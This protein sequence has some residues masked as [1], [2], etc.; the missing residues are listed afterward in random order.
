MPLPVDN[1]VI[2]TRQVIDDYLA[3]FHEIALKEL[4]PFARFN[5]KGGL[6]NFGAFL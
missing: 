5:I 4:N 6:F 2:I 1:S 3:N